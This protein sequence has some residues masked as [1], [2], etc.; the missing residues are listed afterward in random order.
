MPLGK[1]EINAKEYGTPKK[2]LVADFD[3][4]YIPD[5]I[6]LFEKA[7]VFYKGSNPGRFNPPVACQIAMGPGLS[8]AYVGDYDADGLLDVLA[9]AEDRNRVWHNVGKASFVE[10]LGVSGEIASSLPYLAFTRTVCAPLWLTSD[11]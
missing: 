10:M 3:G 2:C 11:V 6:Q 7:G 8:D 4:D 9:L 5:V 1:L